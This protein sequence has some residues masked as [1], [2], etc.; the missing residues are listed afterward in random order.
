M[1]MGSGEGNNVSAE[2]VREPANHKLPPQRKEFEG[3][4]QNVGLANSFLWLNIRFILNAYGKV[5]IRNITTFS[6]QGL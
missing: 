6:E 3:D 2:A 4:I 5:R 1:G